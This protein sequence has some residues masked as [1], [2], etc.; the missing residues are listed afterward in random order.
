MYYPWLVTIPPLLVL[1]VALWSR[2]I[3]IAF[4]VGILTAALVVANFNPF[5]TVSIIGHHTFNTITAIDNLYV[6]AFLLLMGVV[7]SLLSFTG[8]ATA[9]GDK[10]SNHIKTP[11]QAEQSTL[12]LSILLFLDDYLNSLTVGY[13]MHP[14]TD[15]FKI[16][17]VKL[18]FIIHSMTAPLAMIIPVSSW[19]AWIIKQ[20]EL[21]GISLDPSENPI[22]IADPFYVYIKSI[23]Y[24]FYSLVMIF[25]TI[26]VIN[27][28]ISF[29]PMAD[30]EQV[31][32]ETGNLFGGKPP[33][34]HVLSHDQGNIHNSSLIDFLF[35]IFTLIGTTIFG[36][37]YTGG[38]WMLGGPYSLIQA[39]QHSEIFP[40]LFYSCIITLALSIPLFLFHRKISLPQIPHIFYKGIHL[41]IL[42]V[43]MVFFAG[44]FAALLR[45]DLKTG[46]YVA[47][48]L[49]NYF[50]L[51]FLPFLLFVVSALI[52]T[53]TGSSWGTMAIMTPFA[54]PFLIDLLHLQTPTNL[55]GLCFLFPCLG[56]VFSGSVAGDHISPISETTIMATTSSG[57]HVMDHVYTQLPYGAIALVST[58][59]AFLVAGFVPCGNYWISVGTSLGTGILISVI[60]LLALNQ[61]SRK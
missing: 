49:I 45:E 1:A 11:R 17:R 54:V 44:I 6:Y 20:I 28:R 27:R 25:I 8:A 13:V 35:P 47:H 52:A 23:P 18:A 51:Q 60:S 39:L 55:D 57:S 31:A 41:M 43:I 36:I 33:I 2:N 9:F 4:F 24:I 7:V 16:P 10:V 48:L 19:L 32:Q 3:I 21:S 53:C 26:F 50:S 42:A 29:G 12:F 34:L 15:K 37:L 14:L 5:A 30:H 59:A 40:I 58:G 61:R 22:I 38:F 46:E 56:A